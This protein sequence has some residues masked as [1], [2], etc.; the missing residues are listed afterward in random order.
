MRQFFIISMLIVA[1]CASSMDRLSDMREA[2]PEWYEARKTELAGEGYPSLGDVPRN[3]TY[4]RQQAQLVLTR[5]EQDQILAAFNAD[6]RSEP[7][8]VTPED[9]LAWS[10]E[11][12]A[13]VNAQMRPAQFLS[14]AEIASLKARFDRPR[15]RR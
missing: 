6:P 15:A 1:G 12:R 11:L 10:A 8:N 14:D 5:E 9:I 2:A 4:R 13:R 3:A 7:V